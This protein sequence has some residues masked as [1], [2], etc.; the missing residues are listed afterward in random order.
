MIVCGRSLS[1]GVVLALVALACERH[2]EMAPPAPVPAP[3]ST[4]TE[5]AATK[6]TEAASR[7]P[8]SE[9]PSANAKTTGPD[10]LTADAAKGDWTSDAPGVRR[11]LTTS[12]LP[13]PYASES[14][15]NQPDKVS[16]PEGAWPK[17]PAGFLVEKFASDLSRSEEHTSELQSPA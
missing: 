9:T 10:V 6:A 16:Q 11:K 8:K 3:V 15:K 1:L 14:V 2:Q 17:V 5:T 7:T 4:G 12:D 13:A